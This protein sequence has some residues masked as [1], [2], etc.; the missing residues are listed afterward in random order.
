VTASE[1]M[2]SNWRRRV[3]FDLPGACREAIR[4]VYVLRERR[5][6]SIVNAALAGI[7]VRDFPDDFLIALL[8]VTSAQA[9]EYPAREGFFLRVREKLAGK[10]GSGKADKMLVGLAC[11]EGWVPKAG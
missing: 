4:T 11:E 7:N 2:I 5:S 9:V 6:F 3:L 8:M 10:R 1:F